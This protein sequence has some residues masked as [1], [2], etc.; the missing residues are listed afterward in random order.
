MDGGVFML[1]EIRNETKLPP[2]QAYPR[3][4][5]GMELPNTAKLVY[6]L[7]LDRARLSWKNRDWTNGDGYVYVYYTISAMSRA[8]HKCEVTVKTAYQNLEKAG[9]IRRER[10]G[11][12]LPNRIY[13]RLPGQTDSC[14]QDGQN[15]AAQGA[16]KLSGN[17]KKSNN[18]TS[19]CY[20]WGNI[21]DTKCR[22]TAIDNVWRSIAGRRIF[23]QNHRDDLL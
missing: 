16:E 8:L 18:H 9:L 12:N 4:L 23:G 20:E 6:A 22:S 1:N 7:L 2:Y 10:Q 14:T 15:C 21:C 5:L 19:K 13:V 17:N 3:F 11:R